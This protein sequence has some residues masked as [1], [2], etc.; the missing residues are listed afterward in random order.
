MLFSVYY[1]GVADQS[2]LLGKAT[3]VPSPRPLS[4]TKQ[5]SRCWYTF[6]AEAKRVVTRFRAYSVVALCLWNQ[7]PQEGGPY[8]ITEASAGFRIY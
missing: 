2:R 1:S 7:C 5:N 8:F 4:L 3:V 6:Q